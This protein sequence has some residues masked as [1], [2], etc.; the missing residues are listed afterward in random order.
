MFGR[1][2]YRLTARMA[3]EEESG[4]YSIG[5]LAFIQTVDDE[6][7]VTSA[8]VAF[9]KDHMAPDVR[10]KRDAAAESDD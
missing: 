10:K 5:E 9:R 8:G 3:P 4:R 2:D 1:K 7:Y 6:E